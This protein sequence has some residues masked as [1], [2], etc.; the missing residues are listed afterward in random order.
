M[1]FNQKGQVLTLDS[2]A[3]RASLNGQGE[4]FIR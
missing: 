2:M 3:L 4:L 1:A